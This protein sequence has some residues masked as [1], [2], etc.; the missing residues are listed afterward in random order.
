MRLYRLPV[1]VLAALGIEW[2][3]APAALKK[4]RENY[5]DTLGYHRLCPRQCFACTPALE[6]LAADTRREVKVTW[7]GLWHAKLKNAAAGLIEKSR[8]AAPREPAL[9]QVA[10]SEAAAALL[11]ELGL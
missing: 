11:R 10:T 2:K 8:A 4:V 9:A 7:V 6:A 3:D 1:S 5:C